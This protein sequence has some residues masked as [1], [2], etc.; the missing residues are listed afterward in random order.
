MSTGAELLREVL[1]LDDKTCMNPHCSIYGRR[2]TEYPPHHIHYTGQGGPDIK[3]NIIT[4][5][6]KC[7][8]KAHRGTKVDGKRISGYKFIIRV[9]NHWLW[10]PEYRW[11]EAHKYIESRAV[12]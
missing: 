6:A 8:T 10:K 3:E 11:A 1:I 2:R 5:C 9:L 4:L 7:H 12:R